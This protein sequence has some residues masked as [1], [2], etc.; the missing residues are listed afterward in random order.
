[1]KTVEEE[2]RTNGLHVKV[3]YMKI[4][5]DENLYRWNEEKGQIK[6]M[7]FRDGEGK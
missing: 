7:N 6:E 5:V 2:T 1:M 3:G 4:R